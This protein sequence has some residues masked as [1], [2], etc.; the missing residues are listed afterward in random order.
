MKSLESCLNHE[1]K[2]LQKYIFK[3]YAYIYTFST[4]P[5][6]IYGLR[7]WNP[8]SETP[9]EHHLEGTMG[10]SLAGGIAEGPS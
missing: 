10:R 1:K 7:K 9:H 2:G 6:R 5:K 4:S 8:D 3:I